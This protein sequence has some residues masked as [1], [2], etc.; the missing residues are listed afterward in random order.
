MYSLK[1]LEKGLYLVGIPALLAFS[2]YTIYSK[3]QTVDRERQ[4][5]LAAMEE[6]YLVDPKKVVK[7][8]NFK[9]KIFAVAV[10]D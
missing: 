10:E 7:L 5:Q 2:G 9:K 6:K 8:E 3:A 4:E 1:M